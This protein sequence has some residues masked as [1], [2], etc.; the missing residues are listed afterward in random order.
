MFREKKDINYISNENRGEIYK[1]VFHMGIGHCIE[2]MQP[3]K[4]YFI[5]AV[6]IWKDVLDMCFELENK[7]I[8]LYQFSETDIP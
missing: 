7:L 3:L 5:Y 6:L 8:C 2:F 1:K 4:R